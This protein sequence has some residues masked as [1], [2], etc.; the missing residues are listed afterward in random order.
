MRKGIRSRS[1]KF[2]TSF[3]S[4]TQALSS[5]MPTHLRI[6]ICSVPCS[7]T[8][9]ALV[10]PGSWPAAIGL[11]FLPGQLLRAF[12][13]AHVTALPSSQSG[14]GIFC[15]SYAGQI[16]DRRK[17]SG[18]YL[19][20][21]KRDRQLRLP[22]VHA[23]TRKSP[24]FQR[25]SPASLADAPAAPASLLKVFQRGLEPLASQTQHAQPWS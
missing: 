11:P 18:Q 25:R 21:Q 6:V 8:L 13:L 12:D 24:A 2:Q 10:P 23:A 4:A 20:T 15:L 3:W 9:K 5:S 22:H 1:L 19:P 16:Q 17:D 14:G 7:A